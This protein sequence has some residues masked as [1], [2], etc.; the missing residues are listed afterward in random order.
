MFTS[1]NNINTSKQKLINLLKKKF[2]LDID[3]KIYDYNEI[4]KMDS[5][6]SDQIFEENKNINAE[7]I[8]NSKLN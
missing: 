5:Q 8:N 1:I 2:K 6:I 3:Y 7:I 4:L